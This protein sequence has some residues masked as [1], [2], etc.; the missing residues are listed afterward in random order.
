MSCDNLP[1]LKRTQDSRTLVFYSPVEGD[2]VFVRSGM[3][4]KTN[5]T[6]LHSIFYSYLENFKE[7]DNNKKNEIVNN[8]KLSILKPMLIESYKENYFL[9]KM[10]KK[11]VSNLKIVYMNKFNENNNSEIINYLY[12][13][14]DK[15]M[16][17]LIIELISYKDFCNEIILK[18]LV[19][20]KDNN[21]ELFCKEIYNSILNYVTNIE[22]LKK[23]NINKKKK[24]VYEVQNLIRHIINYIYNI[25]INEYFSK[26]EDDNVNNNDYYLQMICKKLK[27][28][29]FII[30]Q[31]TRMPYKILENHKLIYNK[32]IIVLKLIDSFEIIGKLLEKN[33]IQRDFNNN[34]LIIKKIKN[35][36]YQP[37][38]IRYNFPELI[39]FLPKKYKRNI[40]FSPIYKRSPKKSPEGYKVKE[41]DEYYSDS[42]D[43]NDYGF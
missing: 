14:I 42:S 6:F 32:N 20:F 5:D 4:K 33:K 19:K 23:S 17:N 3:I 10:C 7:F 34:N 13:Y 41:E 8:F 39:E 24:F 15:K 22:K 35:F 2:D 31:K 38:N 12:S 29:I 21:F 1:E 28:N 43:D 9:K 30:D 27:R 18:S 26:Y 11:I 37:E 36:I 16:C 25:E 40:K